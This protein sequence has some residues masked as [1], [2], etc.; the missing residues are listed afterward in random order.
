MDG[1]GKVFSGWNKLMVAIVREY[2]SAEKHRYGSTSLR[3]I[4]RDEKK[5][6]EDKKQEILLKVSGILENN[7]L[8]DMDE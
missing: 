5:I 7:L 1:Y 4:I 3:N 2:F 8:W 6:W